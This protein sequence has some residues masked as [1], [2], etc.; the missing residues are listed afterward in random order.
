MAEGERLALLRCAVA[1]VRGGATDAIGRR[2]SAPTPLP[3][4]A[5]PSGSSVLRRLFPLLLRLAPSLRRGVALTS[6]QVGPYQGEWDRANETARS[7]EGRLWAVLGDSAAQGIGASS[8]DHGYVGLLTDRLEARDGRAWRVLNLSRSGARVAD[9]EGVQL[10]LLDALDAPPDLVTCV[11]GGNDLLNTPVEVAEASFRTVLARL[12]AGSVMGTVPQ[13]MRRPV[14]E[15]LN[16]LIR[17]EAP[18]AGHLVADV[19]AHSGKPWRGYYAADQFHPND[20]GYVRWADALAEPLGL[21]T[22]WTGA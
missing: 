17:R 14:A 20:A 4:P 2:R 7:A 18:V 12:P 15:R 9:V 19:W 1:Q 21:P 5:P 6:S 22:E 8:Y 16:A 3:V 11:V 13:G 10:D